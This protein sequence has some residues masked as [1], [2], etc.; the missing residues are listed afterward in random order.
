MS[1][2]GRSDEDNS[3]D[4][5]RYKEDDFVVAD[6]AEEEEVPE[7]APDP[8]APASTE[9]KKKKKKKW[10]E[11]RE[12]DEDDL[13]LLIDNGVKVKRPAA[14]NSRLK[15]LKKNVVEDDPFDIAPEN[16]SKNLKEKLFS[17]VEG[18]EDNILEEEP[19]PLEDEDNLSEEENSEDDMAEFIEDTDAQGNVIE[20]KRKKKTSRKSNVTSHQMREAAALFGGYDDFMNG[21]EYEEGPKAEKPT[22]LIDQF[23]PAVLAERYITPSDDQIRAIDIPERMQARKEQ[24]GEP[25]TG[26]AL[27]AELREESHWIFDRVFAS[28]PEHKLH[29]AEIVPKITNIL[30]YIRKDNFEIPYI[31]QYKKD[32]FFSTEVSLRNEH[33]WDIYDNDGK[34]FHLQ[35]AKERCA[36]NY[37]DEVRYEG[38]REKY[39]QMLEYTQTEADVQDLMDHWYLHSEDDPS[40]GHRRAVK[41]DMFRICKRN[42]VTGFLKYFGMTAAQFGQNMN[43]NTLIH[44]PV[45]EESGPEEYAFRY[46]T[47]ELD[48]IEKIL[49]AARS[50]AAQE[51]AYD[52]LV[53][54]GVRTYYFSRAEISTL[55]TDKGKT[56]DAFHPYRRFIRIKS[57]PA[58]DFKD[59]NGEDTMDWLHLIKAEQE[60]FLTITLGLPVD[61]IT[62]DTEVAVDMEKLYLSEGMSDVSQSWNEERKKIIREALNKHILPLFEKDLKM[63]MFDEAQQ[64]VV[65]LCAENLTHRLLAGPYLPPSYN[66]EDEYKE[67]SVMACAVGSSPIE[68]TFCVLLDGHGAVVTSLKLGYIGMKNDTRRDKDL[69]DIRAF[70]LQHEPTV[71]AVGAELGA[72]ALKDSLYEIAEQLER[73]RE[74]VELIHVAYVDMEV[75]KIFQNSARA[76]VEFP[77]YPT[78]LRRAVSIGRYLQDPLT[79][80]CALM[81]NESEEVL[82]L[83]LHPL[84]GVVQKEKMLETLRRCF[85]NIVNDVGV[86]INRCAAYKFA[87]VNLQFVSGLGPRK[88][89]GILNAISRRGGRIT[90]RGDLDTIVGPCIYTNM[91]GFIRITERYVGR[92]EDINSLD[93]TR[94]HPH[95]YNLVGKIAK[96]ALDGD[97]IC[98][99]LTEKLM[100]RPQ[101]M[102]AI[103][104]DHF[105]DELERTS[106]IKKRMILSRTRSSTDSKIRCSTIKDRT[107][108]NCTGCLTWRTLHSR[109]ECW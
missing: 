44:V 101:Q 75:P 59:M 73:D 22:S 86:D 92:N 50:A 10:R 99:E 42:G 80:M 29:S 17:S 96:D 36:A 61:P 64:K 55:P 14:G 6:N 18:D 8:N 53:R 63:K 104:L 25:K 46:S 15:R 26:A 41:R 12:L 87:S 62:N 40:S 103:E 39:L 84:Q 5:D 20:K 98:D 56:I 9:K 102:A 4:E 74:V 16:F 34:W 67:I 27:E 48:N 24:R 83:Q 33:L 2:S 49:G 90:Q 108:R 71:I 54:Q 106:K 95:D 89:V 81:A 47:R 52:P 85:I 60:G 82:Y 69:A 100:K 57:R 68:P 7:A 28:D 11:P 13:D 66:H 58:V 3:E 105:G 23:E 79:E 107:R 72:R 45:D 43:S 37:S 32:Y 93:N 91:A 65:K 38:D 78:V 19:A 88:S 35:R 76:Q 21:D 31:W 70:I 1:D 97:E 94:I 30:D 109:L 51:I 77:D